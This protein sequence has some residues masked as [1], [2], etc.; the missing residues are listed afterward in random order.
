M[1][2]TFCDICDD[3]I[4]IIIGY[5]KHYTYLALLKMTCSSNYNSVSKFSIAKL[6]LSNSLGL[7]SIRTYCANINCC[8]DTEKVFYIHYQNDNPG[9]EHVRQL[10]LNETIV[11]IN[12][13]KHSLNTHYCSECFKKFVLVRELKN[14]KH[15]YEWI[16][17]LNIRYPKRK[18]IFM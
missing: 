10:A 5:V 18:L 8:Q 11:L 4:E 1:S 13:K 12:D 17:E 2:L 3:V 7:F 9:Y 16:D 6:K 14:I 15:N